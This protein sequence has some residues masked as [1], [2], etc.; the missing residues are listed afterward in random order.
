MKNGKRFLALFMSLL[1]ACSFLGV[2]VSAAQNDEIAPLAA[3]GGTTTPSVTAYFYPSVTLT[4]E[5]NLKSIPEDAEWTFEVKPTTASATKATISPETSKTI[6]FTLADFDIENGVVTA[7]KKLSGTSGRYTM[8]LTG[9]K[10]ASSSKTYNFEFTQTISGGGKFCSYSTNVSK[11]WTAAVKLEIATGGTGRQNAD[12]APYTSEDNAGVKV[13][14]SQ[15]DGGALF[16]NTYANDTDLTVLY[17]DS[18]PAESGDYPILATDVVENAEG[19]ALTVPEALEPAAYDGEEIGNFKFVGWTTEAVSIDGDA[20]YVPGETYTITPADLGYENM[21]IVDSPVLVLYPVFKAE[22]EGVASLAVEGVEGTYYGSLAGAMEYASDYA[23]RRGEDGV[24]ANITV[25]VLAD[26]TESS[27]FMYST[28]RH[29]WPNRDVTLTLNLNGAT[30]TGDGDSVIRFHRTGAGAAGYNLAII[31]NGDGGTITGGYGIHGGG[32]AFDLDGG[33]RRTVEINDVN[34]TYNEAVYDYLGTSYPN[35]TGDGGAVAYHS[36]YYADFTFN[37]CT[38]LGNKAGV[39]NTEAEESADKG[40]NGGALYLLKAHT[41]LNNCT[42]VDNSANG[43]GGGFYGRDIDASTSKIYGNSA[44]AGADDLFVIWNTAAGDDAVKLP[45]SNRYAYYVDAPEDRYDAENEHWYDYFGPAIKDP[46]E[47]LDDPFI[48][49]VY[50]IKAV[51]MAIVTLDAN[52]GTVDPEEIIILPG[53]AIGELPVP[54]RE[55]Y[56]FTGWYYADGTLV[57]AEDI[58]DGDFTLVAGWKEIP[59][60]P[61]ESEDP[62]TPEP[63]TNPEPPK[64]PATTPNPEIPNTSGQ[65]SLMMYIALFALCSVCGAAVSFADRKKRKANCK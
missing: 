52:G 54:V 51:E 39:V 2:A 17:Y 31:V 50:Y 3:G 10:G 32:F 41:V 53:S 15:T 47:T 40:G 14:S 6:T 34:F 24:A 25:D 13:T 29:D 62:V 33:I 36:N 60:V 57:T 21:E 7:T 55:G 19:W 9:T 49:A 12:T 59:E 43:F 26:T 64:T 20:K 23:T 5:G 8:K 44:V 58:V 35:S 48:N 11:P 56:T 37:N 1:L 18:N 22:T 38:F 4:L 46:D 65:E 27:D 45:Q 61:A 42:I 28:G 63:P 16:T 30:V